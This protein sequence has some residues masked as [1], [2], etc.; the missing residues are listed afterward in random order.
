[1]P[2][3]YEDDAARQRRW[4]DYFMDIALRTARMSK[5]PSTKVGAVLVRAD[6]PLRIISTG[7][8]GFP[9]G[10]YD[11]AARLNDRDLK[12]Q[13]VV[14]AEQNALLSAAAEGIST[15][16]SILYIAACDAAGKNAW[17][18]PPCIRCT[19][20]LIQAGV[21]GVVSRPFKDVPSRWKESVELAR[22]ALE[23][24]G[25]SYREYDHEEQYRTMDEPKSAVE[26]SFERSAEGQNAAGAPGK[27]RGGYRSMDDE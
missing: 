10:I 15:K 2:K 7:Y 6:M 24:A 21:I 19:V 13:L 12:L 1:M 20:E 8:N 17:G 5:D 22:A 16:G 26:K 11:T 25:I 4:D 14:H 27:T 3:L 18:G 23:E 9:S